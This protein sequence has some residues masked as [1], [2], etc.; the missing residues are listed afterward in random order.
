MRRRSTLRRFP[1]VAAK[2]I[3]GMPR[4]PV[5]VPHPPLESVEGFGRA[6]VQGAEEWLRRIGGDPGQVPEGVHR[7]LLRRLEEVISPSAIRGVYYSESMSEKRELVGGLEKQLKEAVHEVL[8]GP[9][10]S[11]RPGRK[12]ETDRDKQIFRMK[13]DGLS[14]GQIAAK[15][16]IPRL[17]AQSAYRREQTRRRVSSELVRELATVLKPFGMVLQEEKRPQARRKP[18]ARGVAKIPPANLATD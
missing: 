6:L 3:D 7:G 13:Q 14:Y 12:R 5:V 17:T 2:V 8:L 18:R 4:P 16:K 11:A 9:F 10:A 1:P 15:L